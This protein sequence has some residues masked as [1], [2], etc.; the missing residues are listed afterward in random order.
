MNIHEDVDDYQ[1]KSVPY[2]DKSSHCLV[3]YMKFHTKH[4]FCSL[5]CDDVY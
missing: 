4:I 2:L 3:E 5:I 1:H